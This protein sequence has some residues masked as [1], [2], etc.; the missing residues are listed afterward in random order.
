MLRLNALLSAVMVALPAMA[1]AQ[2][3]EGTVTLNMTGEDGSSRSISYM[4]KGGKMRFDAP[5]GQMTAIIDPVAQRMMLIMNAQKMYMERDFAGAMGTVQQQAGAKNPSV[6]RTGKMETIAGYKCEH[7][8][9][10]DDDG[11]TVDACV[12]SEL[13]GFRL[14]AASNPMAPQKEAG[15]MSQL[16]G[17]SFPLKVMKGTKTIM[18][19]S[20]IEKKALDPALFAPPEG[21][22]SFAMPKRPTKK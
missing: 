21:Y 4:L 19:V 7:L 13:G 12:S 9:I 11:G 10:T 14:P 17:T 20:S 1:A 3:F 5:G 6:V 2:S 15:W 22:Q 16:G 8:T 18:V